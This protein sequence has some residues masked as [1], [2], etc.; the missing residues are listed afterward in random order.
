MK[1]KQIIVPIL[2]DEYK[3]IVCFGTPEKIKKVLHQWGHKP[4][5]VVLDNENRRGIC[6]HTFGCHPIIAM[7]RFPKTPQ[8]IG[9]LTHESVH[10][11][12][13]IMR[14]IEQDGAEEVYAHSV[15]AIVRKVLS[16]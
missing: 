10:A 13:D 3:V 8:E 4:A 15:S 6:Y 1:K 16:I 5:D 11:V 14:M 9:T 12:A 7:P 2:N